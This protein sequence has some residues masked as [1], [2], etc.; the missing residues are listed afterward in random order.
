MPNYRGV[1]SWTRRRFIKATLGTS[2]LGTSCSDLGIEEEKPLFEG[3]VIEDEAF[4]SLNARYYDV[5]VHAGTQFPYRAVIGGTPIR[6]TDPVAIA[7]RLQY[8]LDDLR[9]V[10]QVDRLLTS[11]LAAQISER[12]PRNFRNMLPRLAL[13]ESGV[14]PAT[15]EYS[16][17]D[18]ALLSSRVAMAAQAYK[19]TAA[20]DKALSFLD[21]QKLGYN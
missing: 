7:F 1:D 13:L 6:E 10:D 19:G 8:L 18:N 20:G 17:T 11:L 3:P 5:G 14:A 21:R 4:V 16:F 15:L 12:P 2:L 9:K